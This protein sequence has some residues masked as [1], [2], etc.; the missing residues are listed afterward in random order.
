VDNL[1]ESFVRQALDFSPMGDVGAAFTSSSVEPV[2]GC[3]G[4]REDLLALGYVFIRGG[5]AGLL[6][7]RA[8]GHTQ[9]CERQGGQERNS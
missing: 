4:G 2:T 6:G 1:D 7:V 5:L 9:Q 8:S 3:A